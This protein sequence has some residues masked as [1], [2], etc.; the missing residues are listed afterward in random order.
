MNIINYLLWLKW[1]SFVQCQ[2]VCI[3]KYNQIVDT[4][5]IFK[6]NYVEILDTGNLKTFLDML[7]WHLNN[8]PHI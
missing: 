5:S 3:D 6:D 1:R 2:E 8:E 4:T 7:N